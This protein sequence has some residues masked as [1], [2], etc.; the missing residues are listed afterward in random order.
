MAVCW[1][2][3]A[4]ERMT[5]G[6]DELVPVK[7]RVGG[8]YLGSAMAWSAPQHLAPFGP[9]SRSMGSRSPPR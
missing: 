6:A 5:G 9:L 8:R 2:R 4:G 3:F 1:I 7:L